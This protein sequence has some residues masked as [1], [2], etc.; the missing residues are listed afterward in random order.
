MHVPL[1]WPGRLIGCCRCQCSHE[2][3]SMFAPSSKDFNCHAEHTL[4]CSS[5]GARSGPTVSESDKE[6]HCNTLPAREVSNVAISVFSCLLPSRK[7]SASLRGL[8]LFLSVSGNVSSDVAIMPPCEENE[9]CSS[10]TRPQHNRPQRA[11]TRE[12]HRT[13]AAH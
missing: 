9:N 11:Q 3:L 10:K 2:R 12:H 4:L 6:R 5:S 13:T 1:I 8:F 7:T